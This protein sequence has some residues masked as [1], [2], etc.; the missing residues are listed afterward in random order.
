ML[1][2]LIVEGGWAS[3]ETQ[4]I[5]VAHYGDA[6]KQSVIGFVQCMRTVSYCLALIAGRD[7]FHFIW[8]SVNS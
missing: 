6:K 7:A 8:F 3:V 2:V 5:S 4:G 1:S